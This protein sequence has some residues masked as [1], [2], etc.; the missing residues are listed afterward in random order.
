MFPTNDNLVSNIKFFV[1]NRSVSSEKLA[2]QLNF[3][4]AQILNLCSTPAE[5]IDGDL[6]ITEKC[7]S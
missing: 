1:K 7:S 3:A 6:S 2:E 5:D 4:D